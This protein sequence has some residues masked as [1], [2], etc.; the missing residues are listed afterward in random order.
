MKETKNGNCHNVMAGT[1]LV[2]SAITLVWGV[3]LGTCIYK[4]VDTLY[5]VGIETQY[6]S[7]ANF[8]A[9]FETSMT[10]T[11]RK[12]IDERVQQAL[13]QMKAEQ[14][15]NDGDM[16][17]DESNL[18]TK[19]ALNDPTWNANWM[20]ADSLFGLRGTPGNAVINVKNGNFKA[21]SGAYPQSAFEAVIAD[22]KAGK[23]LVN[24]DMGNAG[25]LTEKQISLLL[26]GAHFN[27]DQNADIVIVEYSDLLCPF[28]Q[29]H[30]N[31]K[32]LENII[33]AD[34]SVALVFK[35]M[36][37][38]SLHPNAPLGAKGVEC[39]GELWGSEHFYAYLDKAFAQSD[40][41]GSNVIKIAEE[42]G[43]DREAF[44][45]CFTK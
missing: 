21:V 9:I 30:Y 35:N 4:K 27:G 41:N 19:A 14:E 40:F 17:D 37:I 38:V 10:P 29:R 45:A 32:T 7:Q 33:A 22:L 12:Q 24:D 20:E 28:C 18:D 6:G 8:D 26:E 39:A 34:S 42:I 44:V 2:L 5:K 13:Q 31:D 16:A 11:V 36:P 43:L 15:K 1:A 23:E 3:V 25:K